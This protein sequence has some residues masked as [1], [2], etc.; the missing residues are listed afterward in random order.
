MNRL[1]FSCCFVTQ[2]HI[3]LRTNAIFIH[4][5]TVKLCDLMSRVSLVL[6]GNGFFPCGLGAFVDHEERVHL[7][8]TIIYVG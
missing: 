8:E 3:L 2:G 6:A 1:A 7:L 5:L 4:I